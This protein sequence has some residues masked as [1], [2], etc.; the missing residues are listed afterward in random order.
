M[1]GQTGR[2][3]EAIVAFRKFANTLQND[4]FPIKTLNDWPLKW[5]QFLFP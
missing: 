1:N 3:D 5:K 2:Y 4:G